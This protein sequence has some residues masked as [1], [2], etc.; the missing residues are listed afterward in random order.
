MNWA[1]LENFEEYD[2]EI[3]CV[4][5]KKP[6]KKTVVGDNWKCHECQHIFK[7][8]GS[9]IECECHCK[10]C[11]PEHDPLAGKTK[12]KKAELQLPEKKIKIPSEA[13]DK[14]RKNKRLGK[15]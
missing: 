13:G 8:D 14:K 7:E 5:C 3:P 1:D 9:K 15:S 6:A 10:V 11:M 12:S 2:K 4:L